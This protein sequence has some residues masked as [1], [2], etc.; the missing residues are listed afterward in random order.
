VHKVGPAD[1]KDALIKGR[2]DFFPMLDSLANPFSILLLGIIYPVICIYLISAGA[3][4]IFPFMSGLALVGPVT[5]I[6]FYEVSRRRQLNLD[7]SWTHVLELRNSRSLPSIFALGLLLLVIFICWQATAECLY[8]WLFGATAPDS[9]KAFV[10][11]IFTTWRGWTLIFLGNIIGFAFAAVVLSI[12][13][14]SF[15]LILDRNVGVVSAIQTSIEAVMANPLTMALWGLVV[16]ASLVIGFLLS[17][18]G[19]VF[20]VPVL[21]HAN[22]HL[23]E[24]VV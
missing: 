23:Y 10:A 20:V 18:V 7:T 1:L 3:Q 14:V 9:P 22:W 6:G 17:F 8:V 15:P 5:A 19:L 4:L 13:V 21:A 11:E 12:S 2:N 16:A 24:K